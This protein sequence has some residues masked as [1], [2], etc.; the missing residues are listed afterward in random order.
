MYCPK[1]LFSKGTYDFQC[2]GWRAPFLQIGGDEM[3]TALERD[4]FSYDCSMPSRRFGYLDLGNTFNHF[5]SFFVFNLLIFLDFGL[6]PYSLKF[7]SI[8]VIRVMLKI[9]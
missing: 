8:Q 7:A 4:G 1:S 3:F 5:I 9:R 2:L 6:F